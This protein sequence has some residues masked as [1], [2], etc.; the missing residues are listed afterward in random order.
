ADGE[1]RA[2]D[3]GS[4]LLRPEQLVWLQRAK[5][6]V[7]GPRNVE[8]HRVRM[9]LRSRIAIDGTSGVVLEFRDDPIA[10]CFR[11][12]IATNT[13]LDVPRQRVDRRPDRLPMGIAES[14]VVSNQCGERDTLRR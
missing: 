12:P 8:E 9:E 6:A 5:L 3:S 11:R 2:V 14:N 10:S 7:L 4:E 13:C 1:L